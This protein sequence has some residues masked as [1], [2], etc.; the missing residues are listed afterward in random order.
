MALTRETADGRQ[1]TQVELGAWRGLL[2]LHSSLIRELDAEL[3]AMHRLPLRSYEVLVHLGAAPGRRLRMSDLSRS[4]LLSP[5]GVSRLVDR[6]ESEGFVCR[7]RCEMDGRGFFAVLTDAGEAR[8]CEA[9]P[10]HLAGVRRLFLSHFTADELR[11]LG[12]MLEQAL[13]G[14]SEA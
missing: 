11:R 8:L 3:I 12:A 13:P 6:L 2:R 5:S 14:A 10:T 7:R 1:L 4:V 9:R